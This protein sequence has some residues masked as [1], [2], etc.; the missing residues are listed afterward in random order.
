MISTPGLS[1]VRSAAERFRRPALASSV[2]NKMPT[3]TPF[4]LTNVVLTLDNLTSDPRPLSRI[5][6]LL[7][8][9][10]RDEIDSVTSLVTTGQTAAAREAC[11]QLVMDVL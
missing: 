1:S 9:D 2:S 5:A 6:G 11:S 10:F 8:C 7:A 4:R 3:L